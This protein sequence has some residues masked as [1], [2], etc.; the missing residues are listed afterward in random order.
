MIKFPYLW[1]KHPKKNK[2][3]RVPV[4]HHA[5]IYVRIRIEAIQGWRK[6]NLEKSI[7][8]FYNIPL[9]LL[10][11]LFKKYSGVTIE[12]NDK[13]L[14]K[15]FFLFDSPAAYTMFLLRWA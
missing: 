3:L 1:K 15:F 7:I 12:A 11:L 4:M 2:S 6:D 10:C 13:D 8:D 5:E 9:P 14:E